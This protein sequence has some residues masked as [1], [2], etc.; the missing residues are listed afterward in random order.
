VQS[1]L[2]YF[3]VVN[4]FGG[5]L[6]NSFFICFFKFIIVFFSLVCLIISI[7]F[8]NNV[9]NMRYE[10]SILIG[11]SCIG[12]IFLASANDFISLYLAM[13]LQGLSTYILAGYS[14]RSAFST[15]AG[16][17]YFVIGSFSSGILLLGVVLIYLGCGSLS[18]N[19]IF[20]IYEVVN[21]S[22]ITCFGIC[23]VICALCF[24]LGAAPFHMYLPDI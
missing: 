9:K 3:K 7:S 12:M 8:I 20:L 16:L 24:K 17:K 1:I 2:K 6:V 13:E 10:Y 23:L 14:S 15:E 21:P 18:F 19:N 22:F 4:I 11:F 5:A